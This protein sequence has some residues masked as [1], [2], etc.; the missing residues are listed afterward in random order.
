VLL[1]LFL[2]TGSLPAQD[3]V[4][5][6]RA[7]VDGIDPRIVPFPIGGVVLDASSGQRIADCVPFAA[8]GSVVCTA[9]VPKAVS[10]LRLVLSPLGY[11]P[12]SAN[13][14]E[15]DSSNDSLL[16]D[17]GDVHLQR[18]DAPILAPIAQLEIS[19]DKQY[20][21]QFP[22]AT[23]SAT[24]YRIARLHLMAQSVTRED[25]SPAGGL[26]FT[27]YQIFTLSVTGKQAD[28]ILAIEGLSLDRGNKDSFRSRTFGLVGFPCSG[29]YLS[30][31]LPVAAIVDATSRIA[32]RVTLPATLIRSEDLVVATRDFCHFAFILEPADSALPP[33]LT[34]YHDPTLHKPPS[35]LPDFMDLRRCSPTGLH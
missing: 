29:P 3:R 8:L 7:I 10:D 19:P 4:L 28:G 17:L 18:L 14:L 24:P 33:L 35:M 1:G 27:D 26:G 32:L 22:V 15:L 21:F 30:L 6:V 16:V 12:Y 13:L 34:V 20:R 31:Y 23:S 11:A 9:R 2:T 25:C 5:K